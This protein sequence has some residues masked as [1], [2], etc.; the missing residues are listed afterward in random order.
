MKIMIP[1]GISDGLGVLV[2]E[3]M[4][5]G[6]YQKGGKCALIDMNI[7]YQLRYQYI[8]QKRRVQEIAALIQ[9]H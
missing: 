2:R 7:F 9:S 4:L 1:L 3:F 8:H 5:N 6:P